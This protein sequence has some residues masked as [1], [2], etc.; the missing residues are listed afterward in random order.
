VTVD[1]TKRVDDTDNNTLS[2]VF[3]SNDN[4]GVRFD[5][6]SGEYYNEILDVNGASVKRLNTFFK[7]HLR[8]VDSAVGKVHNVRVEDG[9]LI[10]DVTFGSDED[11]QRIYSKYAE[12][13]LTD[14][15]IGYEIKDYK[16]EKSAENERDNVTVTDFDVFEVSAVGIGFDS[17]AKKREDENA[18]LDGSLEMN[19]EMKKRLEALEAM[20]KRSADENA[21]LQKLVQMREA[22]ITAEKEREAEKLRAENAELK[23]QAEIQAV[24][25]RHGVSA[26]ML[27][28]FIKDTEKTADMLR[29]AILDERAN[30]TQ[31]FQTVEKTDADSLKEAIRDGLA[32]RLGRSKLD[33]IHPDADKYRNA[34]LSQLANLLLPENE[35]S[36]NPVEVAERSMV[37]G[38]FPLLLLSAGNRV[39]ES[40]FEAQMA[41]AGM[42][43]KQ[44]DVPDFRTNTDIVKGQGGRLSKTLENGDL[45]ELT[46][47]ENAESWKLESF[48]NKF[49]LTREMIIND[50]LGAFTDMLSI[51]A[52]MAVTTFNGLSYDLLRGAGDY[53]NYTMADG[54]PI[55]HTEHG[56]IDSNALSADAISTGRTKMRKQKALDGVTPLNIT[57]RYLVVA[58]EL[59]QTAREILFSSSKLD[60]PNAGVVNVIQDMNLQL[61]VDAELASPTEWYLLADRRTIKVGFLSGTNRR[62]VVKMTDNSLIR[63]TFEGVFDIGFVA[64]DYRGMYQGNQ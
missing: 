14:V 48:G 60:A 32:L 10:G 55:F 61:I 51:F 28:T 27:D 46:I 49:V 39:L 44:V 2:F 3:V 1:V 18:N 53:A 26:S 42:F 4:A 37:T 23:R 36:F 5:W 52:T 43:V 59:E 31:G 9:Q 35:R 64:E 54:L 22:E 63:T 47:D 20:A 40:E 16:V 58:P 29:E 34:P 15:S 56:N 12:G 19:D 8:S 38:D 62:P 57:P 11:S 45:K 21:E 25:V 13:I 6:G 41:T 7:D 33:D 30:E 50:D 24:A 17:G